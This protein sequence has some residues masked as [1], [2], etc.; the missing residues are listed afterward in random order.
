MFLIFCSLIQRAASEGPLGTRLSTGPT[1]RLEYIRPQRNA[2]SL[3]WLSK[4]SELQLQPRSPGLSCALSSH[5]PW[6]FFRSWNKSTTSLFTTFSKC[7][8]PDTECYITLTP[9]LMFQHKFLLFRDVFT[10]TLIIE[11]PSHPSS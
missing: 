4:T 1:R 5:P 8:F 11:D 9:P 10:N 3:T 7:C 6:S 2:N